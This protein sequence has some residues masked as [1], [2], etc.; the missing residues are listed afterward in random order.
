MGKDFRSIYTLEIKHIVIVVL[1]VILFWNWYSQRGASEQEAIPS[2]VQMTPFTQTLRLH[3]YQP[4]DKH[5]QSLF[6]ARR[7]YFDCDE[8]INN[9]RKWYGIEIREDEKI[10]ANKY[11]NRYIVADVSPEDVAVLVLLCQTDR[12]HSRFV[13]WMYLPTESVQNHGMDLAQYLL[14]EYELAKN[15]PE[16]AVRKNPL[17]RFGSVARFPI[18]PSQPSVT[19]EEEKALLDAYIAKM[20][21][22]AYFESYERRSCCGQQRFAEEKL[23]QT[24]I[25]KITANVN[26]PSE[27]KIW[28]IPLIR[29]NKPSIDGKLLPEEWRHSL[30]IPIGKES[31]TATLYLQSDGDWLYIGSNASS[32][33]NPDGH[34]G[35]Y[36][37][38]HIGITPL[39]EYVR[40]NISGTRHKYP[41]GGHYY[42]STIRDFRYTNIKWQ[43][44]APLEYVGH[45]GITKHSIKERGIYLDS[46]GSA[47]FDQNWQYELALSLGESAIHTGVPFTAVIKI[48]EQSRDYKNRKIHGQLGQYEG[49]KQDRYSAWFVIE[50]SK[51]NDMGNMSAQ[52]P[53]NRTLWKDGSDMPWPEAMDVMKTEAYATNGKLYFGAFTSSSPLKTMDTLIDAGLRAEI[54]PYEVF[55][56]TDNNPQTGSLTPHTDAKAGYEYRLR[57]HIDDYHDK[58]DESSDSNKMLNIYNALKESLSAQVEDLQTG[59]IFQSKARFGKLDSDKKRG[60]SQFL[61]FS[62]PYEKLILSKGDV[63]RL[64]FYE[65]GHSYDNPQ[66]AFSPDRQLTLD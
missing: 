32:D 59:K 10:S 56:D 24:A 63:I 62:I 53:P 55:I 20:S 18:R 31:N 48:E 44:I 37:Y 1:L 14:N 43:G 35:F 38:N 42:V 7:T 39:L 6:R 19:S 50:D 61:S 66:L 64:C 33:Q 58:L 23:V 41:V 9:L 26:A 15:T 17:V 29:A 57:Y 27:V 30:Q 25:A 12:G 11:F 16:E 34:H 36:Y 52:T 40:V 8:H 60:D 3:A 21:N 22:P 13:D 28:K 5:V 47:V 54:I 65:A 46:Y 2:S 51:K 49:L 45:S 4:P